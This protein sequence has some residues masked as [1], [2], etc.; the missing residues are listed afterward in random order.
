MTNKPGPII[1]FK[2]PAVE[3][4]MH[5]LKSGSFFPLLISSS[6]NY[7]LTSS[8]I[9]MAASPTDYIVIAENQ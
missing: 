2:L 7:L 1:Y 9:A 4:L 8:T 3:I 6:Y 5:A